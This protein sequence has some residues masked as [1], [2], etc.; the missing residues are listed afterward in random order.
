MSLETPDFL[1]PVGRKEWTAKHSVPTKTFEIH[2]PVC[3]LVYDLDAVSIDEIYCPLCENDEP[4][5]AKEVK[6]G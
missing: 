5:K 6:S 4:I 2:C 3:G 1:G